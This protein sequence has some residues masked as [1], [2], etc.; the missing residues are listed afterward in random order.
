MCRRR[1]TRGL[2]A[3][4]PPALNGRDLA[5]PARGLFEG[6]H[7]GERCERRRKRTRKGQPLLDDPSLI[8]ESHVPPAGSVELPSDIPAR[9]W[10]RLFIE[11]LLALARK[12]RHAADLLARDFEQFMLSW[13]RGISSQG[14]I[15]QERWLDAAIAEIRNRQAALATGKMKTTGRAF[16]G[17]S[18][19]WLL[20]AR[21]FEK[22]GSQA[23][24][25]REKLIAR[26][27]RR[28]LSYSK[29][30]T[31]LEAWADLLAA[32]LPGSRPRT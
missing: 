25:A 28:K 23:S 21:G 18:D 20:W 29:A 12:D 26:V 19:R 6:L 31:A 11:A 7:E 17:P 24:A 5:R 2:G 9:A 14:T 15:E 10:A 1:P 3:G 13:Q 16:A 8:V 27:P 32:R 30:R 4:G 22:D